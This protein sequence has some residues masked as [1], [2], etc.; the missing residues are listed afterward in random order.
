MTRTVE[1]LAA[2][3]PTSA[4]LD[5]GGPRR[6]CPDSGM[7]RNQC[8][9][10]ASGPRPWPLLSRRA[11]PVPTVSFMLLLSSPWGVSHTWANIRTNADD[12]AP[13][14]ASAI[15]QAAG[16]VDGSGRILVQAAVT[17]N[18]RPYSIVIRTKS[19]TPARF[20]TACT[21]ARL[22]LAAVDVAG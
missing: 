17:P 21:R 12:P 16:V 9:S 14:Q 7:A 11:A 4:S 6:T 13:R 10:G 15:T 19:M 5:Q 18:E 20:Y 1:S 3:R 8:Q 2:D 22:E